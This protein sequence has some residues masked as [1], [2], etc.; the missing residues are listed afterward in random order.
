MQLTFYGNK[1][2]KQTLQVNKTFAKLKNVRVVI[3][4]AVSLEGDRKDQLKNSPGDTPNRQGQYD[5]IYIQGCFF[6]TA[7]GGT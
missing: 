6:P 4:T 2:K 3:S 7:S 5:Y 1:R